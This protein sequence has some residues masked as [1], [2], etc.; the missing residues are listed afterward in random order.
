MEHMVMVPMMMPAGTMG[1]DEQEQKIVAPRNSRN[2]RWADAQEQEMFNS[3]KLKNKSWTQ[4]QE[5]APRNMRNL[6]PRDDS[7]Y[8]MNNF[9][10][11]QPEV[12][13]PRTPQERM[14]GKV[15][16]DLS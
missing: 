14:V 10:Q 12:V 4:A 7:L 6:P 11:P 8:A 15:K 5:I 9:S 1:Y 13:K 16:Q 2:K 3:R